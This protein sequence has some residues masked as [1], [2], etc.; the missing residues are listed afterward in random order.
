[1]RVNVF[2]AGGE[3]SGKKINLNPLV[4]DVEPSRN[5]IYSSV[6]AEMWHLKQGSRATKSKAQVKASGRKPWR[7]KGTGRARVGTLGPPIWKGGGHTFAIKPG[8]RAHKVNKKVKQLAR[9]SA[10]SA[11]VK[12]G[13]LKVVEELKFE[14]NK[15]SQMRALLKNLGI[16]GVNSLL[17]LKE[18]NENILLSA[19]NIP[20]IM[21]VS[22][23]SSSTLDL[24]SSKKII[25]E[26]GAVEIL[27]NLFDKSEKGFKGGSD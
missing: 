16:D 15:T 27:N 20:N 21:V 22:A 2:T 24:V 18:L 12:A 14:T 25:L 5:A 26:S 19:R 1:M 3:D 11:H 8:L 7:Q 9:K 23:G 4:F 10:F 17:I 6:V 13:T